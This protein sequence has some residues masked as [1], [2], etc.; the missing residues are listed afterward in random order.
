EIVRQGV[1]EGTFTVSQPEQG[2]E[3][4]LS[5]LQGMGNT[6]ARLLLSFGQDSGG[7]D[8]PRIERIVAV[9]TAYMEAIERVLGAPPHSFYRATPE[10]VQ[11]WVKAMREDDPA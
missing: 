6:H 9:H 7:D 2:G 11:V 5:L 1:R 10:A 4:I 3:V 8:Q